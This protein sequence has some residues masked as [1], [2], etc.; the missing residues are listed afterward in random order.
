MKTNFNYMSKIVL[1]TFFMLLSSVILQLIGINIIPQGTHLIVFNIFTIFI[2]YFIVAF[3]YYK[4]A[5]RKIDYKKLF[6]KESL[7][8]AMIGVATGMGIFLFQQ[9]AYRIFI[10]TNTT[11]GSNVKILQSIPIMFMV[12]S[13]VV[14]APIIEE[15]FF[16]GFFYEITNEQTNPYVYYIGTAA[17]FALLH[18]QNL[19]SPIYAIYNLIIVFISGLIF[20][21]VYRKT[22][23]IGTN[24]I[25]HATANGIV[26][27]L[28]ILFG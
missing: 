14:L 10:P 23:W 27:F 20:G 28:L 4:T 8:K 12:L 17:L 22:N 21:L 25:A 18:L 1:L 15:L 9:L 7:S 24:I 26:I 19:D 3:F 5:K 2:S 6:G 16:R 13:A 11:V